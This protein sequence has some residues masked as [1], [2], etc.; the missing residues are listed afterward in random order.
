MRVESIAPPTF[1]ALRGK[2]RDR[3]AGQETVGI[4]Q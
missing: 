3:A 4:N 2:A 1:I